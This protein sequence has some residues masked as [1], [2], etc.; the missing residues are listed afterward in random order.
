MT[1]L[2]AIKQGGPAFEAMRRALEA[3]DLPT[4][5]LDEGGAHFF[6]LETN[7][8]GGLVRLGDVVLLR[9]IVVP[10]NMRRSGIGNVILAGL[11]ATARSW[12]TREAWLLT[13]TAEAFFTAN[14]FRRVPRTEAPALVAATSQFKSICPDSAALM[15]LVLT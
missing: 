4:S 9:S 11:I 15:C 10:P 13:T 14:G 12:G 6:A 1:E 5:D 8:F 7:G 2:R 3:A